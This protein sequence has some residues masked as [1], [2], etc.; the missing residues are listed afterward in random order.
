MKVSDLQFVK[1]FLTQ[2]I[3][4][5]DSVLTKILDIPVHIDY[6]GISDEVHIDN[7]GLTYYNPSS[8][9]MFLF[10]TIET[11][12]SPYISEAIQ[13]DAIGLS[14]F[15]MCKEY[16]LHHKKHQSVIPT[17]VSSEKI[18]SVSTIIHHIIEP[19]LGKVKMV[20]ILYA[21]SNYIDCCKII[22]TSKDLDGDAFKDYKIPHH[23]FPFIL[24]NYNIY[25]CAAQ[26]SDI[27]IK[28][29]EVSFG[30][31]KTQKI[32]KKILIGE[33]KINDYLV[34]ILK[35]S[36]LGSDFIDF[37]MFLESYV[38]L[39]QNEKIVASE[40][41]LKIV[42]SDKYLSGITKISQQGNQQ[43]GNQWTQWSMLMGLIE[44]QLEP[45]RGSMWPTT[46]SMKPHEDKLRKLIR[47]KDDGEHPV[48]EKML[49][50]ARELYNHKAIEPGKLLETLLK[51]NRIWKI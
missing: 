16:T 9:T 31:N 6:S 42:E 2:E 19:L 17:I 12:L 13:K 45:M 25:N 29:I 50:A 49:E 11:V 14:L 10:K 20:P 23:S 28:I 47:K 44:K 43:S 27:L 33:D 5:D 21:P 38:L 46:E 34:D 48:F 51:E 15:Y 3:D 35:L 37:L 30:K 22:E 40:S 41:L 32:I 1:Y 8:I 24:C 36:G 18:I 4:L 39:Q 7:N 26:E